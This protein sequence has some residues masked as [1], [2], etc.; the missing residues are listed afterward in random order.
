MK[1]NKKAGYI[2][3]VTK[4]CSSKLNGGSHI[5]GIK[6]WAVDVVRCSAGTMDCGVEERASRDRKTRKILAMKCC[7]HSRS[8]VARLY[9]PRKKGWGGGGGAVIGFTSGEEGEQILAWLPERQ[10][11][12]GAANGLEGERAL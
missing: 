8:N 12:V 2:R 7:L 3:R 6:A 11:R 5:S 4:L 1:G 9:L 10:H